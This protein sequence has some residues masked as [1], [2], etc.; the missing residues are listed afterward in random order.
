MSRQIIGRDTFKIDSRTSDLSKPLATFR[1]PKLLIPGLLNEFV[2]TGMIAL[3]RRLGIRRDHQTVLSTDVYQ[4][5]IRLP[6]DHLFEL[7]GFVFELAKPE[8]HDVA[9]R[10]DAFDGSILHHGHMAKSSFGHD[11]QN[12]NE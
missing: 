9:D 7:H 12:R 4:P 2:R 1:I 6:D 8:V 3:E 5:F 10:D 11:P